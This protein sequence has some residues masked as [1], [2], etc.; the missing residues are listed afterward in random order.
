MNIFILGS[1][2]ILA[3]AVI[4][5]CFD[6]KRNLFIQDILPDNPRDIPAA[7]AQTTAGKPMN[8]VMIFGGEEVFAGV[9]NGKRFLSLQDSQVKNIR[10]ICHYFANLD[11]KP[12]TLLIASSTR[13]YARD[14][15]QPAGENGRLGDHYLAGYFKQI[16]NATKPAEEK[17]I[18]VL[19]LR[20]GKVLSRL[21]EPPL[22]FLPI[23]HGSL[24]LFWRDKQRRISWVSQEDAVR[25]ITF[26]LEN[27]RITTPI[28]ITSPSSVPK[29]FF[30]RAIADKFCRKLTPTLP[31]KLVNITFSAEHASLYFAD[32]DSSPVK[33]SRAGFAFHDLT[34]Q[35]YFHNP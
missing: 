4:K 29:D 19:H 30:Y 35:E 34:V 18:R 11:E 6:Q 32:S 8:V 16:E 26:L 5:S 13:I 24:P 10:T 14:E 31:E 33:L 20:L 3:S 12:A 2:T 27:T 28:N 21:V 25:A 7:I 9:L 15:L 22:H 17:G 23:F 1:S